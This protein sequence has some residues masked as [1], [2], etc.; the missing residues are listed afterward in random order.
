[1]NLFLFCI[2][3]RLILVYVAK[4]IS[5]EKLHY[6]GYLTLIPAIGFIIIYLTKIRPR[7]LEV[8]GKKIWWNQLRPIH[9][10]L[11]LVFSIGAMN[12]YNLWY[13]LLLDVLLGV[14]AYI[15]HYKIELF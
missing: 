7:G 6:L 1:M 14:T 11:Y 8:G 5:I 4:T 15:I 9:G 2:L 10:L 3:L 13:L 12:K